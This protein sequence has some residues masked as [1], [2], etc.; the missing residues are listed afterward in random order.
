MMDLGL[1]MAGGMNDISTLYTLTRPFITSPDHTLQKKAYKAL[2]IICANSGPAMGPF[3]AAHTTE[4]LQVFVQ[5]VHTA[6]PA[7]KYHRLSAVAALAKHLPAATLAQFIPEII[8]EVIMCSKEVT[9]RTRAAAY[10]CMI[11][12]GNAI[13]ATADA[14]TAAGAAAALTIQQY[15]ELVVAGLAGQSPHMRSGTILALSRLMY[16]FH[17]NMAPT[18]VDQVVQTVCLL[19]ASR[20]REVLKSSI[21]FV[22]VA[23]TVLAIDQVAQHLKDIIEGVVQEAG[24]TFR[25]KVRRILEKL[26]RMY[27]YDRVAAL[28]PEEHLKLIVNIRKTK[29]REKAKKKAG[30]AAGD[31][32]GAAAAAAA[33][34]LRPVHKPGY[35]ELLDES[36]DSGEEDDEEDEEEEQPR[37]RQG[38]GKGKGKAN[39]PTMYIRDGDE[40]E[41]AVDFLDP[42][43]ASKLRSAAPLQKKKVDGTQFPVL[44]DGKMFIL[45]PEEDESVTKAQAEAY[46]L[47][48]AAVVA[49]DANAGSTSTHYDR[50]KRSRG[51]EDRVIEDDD[52][53]DESGESRAKSGGGASGGLAKKQR[54]LGSEYKGKK[55]AG[56]VYLAGAA[57]PHA[58]L[59]FD[60]AQLNK[61]KKAKAGKEFKTAFT[62]TKKGLAGRG[63]KATKQNKL[64]R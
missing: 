30:A 12:L 51:K 27:G 9:E 31:M 41:D 38:G 26:I 59:A 39:A 53:E 4:L 5:A 43:M 48:G 52:E 22:K 57:N 17:E 7:T 60:K 54:S 47:A 28:M 21:S 1:A 8:T 62:A 45:D 58:Y 56:D 46:G 25:A 33:V 42:S 20:S 29:E 32:G 15:F 63:A 37:G 23:I 10:T 44:E 36:D 61:R 49:S 18:Q 55:A 35:E 13:L 64:R 3:L 34:T 19:M 14:A 11:E 16:Q 2:G 40:E 6:A 24:A 50:R